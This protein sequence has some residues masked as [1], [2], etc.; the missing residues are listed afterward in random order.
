MILV[1]D[2]PQAVGKGEFIEM[3]HDTLVSDIYKGAR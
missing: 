3:Y 1:D 2:D